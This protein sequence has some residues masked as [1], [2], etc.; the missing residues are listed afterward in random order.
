MKRVLQILSIMVVLI[1]CSLWTQAEKEKLIIKKLDRVKQGEVLDT[2]NA[3]VIDSNGHKVN[4]SSFKGKWL[5]IDFWS[6]GCAHCIKEFP[7]LREFYNKNKTRIEVIAVS[8]D[9]DYKRYKKSAN[10]YDIGLPH[11]YGGFTYENDIFNLN[12][13]I[14]KTNEGNYRFITQTPQYVLINPEGKIID[15]E[16]PKPSGKAFKNKLEAYLSEE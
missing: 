3:W 9:R 10:K 4:Y 8:V 16:L 11:F 13:K 7:F 6:T 14:I 5:L 1:H 2:I 12:V 15:K